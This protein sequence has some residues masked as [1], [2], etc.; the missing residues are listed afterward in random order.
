V[1][2]KKLEPRF[3][4]SKDKN[5]ADCLMAIRDNM[6]NEKVWKPSGSL[7]NTSY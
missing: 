6:F 2:L 5:I 4:W 1:N 7:S 3:Q